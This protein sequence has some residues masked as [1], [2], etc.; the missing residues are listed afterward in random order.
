VSNKLKVKYK[1]GLLEIQELPFSPLLPS[2]WR[3]IAADENSQ[4]VFY[5]A[6]SIFETLEA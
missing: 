2:M 1:A 3:E 4:E 6:A 5:K